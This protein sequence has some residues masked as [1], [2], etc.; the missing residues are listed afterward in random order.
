[1]A[2]SDMFQYS[3]F[4][5]N[6]FKIEY[7]GVT[8]LKDMCGKK[9]GDKIDKIVLDPSNGS[10]T[11]KSYSKKIP[12]PKKP[13][14]VEFKGVHT[15]FE[16]EDDDDDLEYIPNVV[17]SSTFKIFTGR[18]KVTRINDDMFDEFSNYIHELGC[19]SKDNLVI[20]CATDLIRVAGVNLES[21]FDLK[22]RYKLPSGNFSI[23]RIF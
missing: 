14:M 10:F 1:M 11:V 22:K 15:R 16:D 21:Y 17:E 6:T 23:M 5:M 13:N 9:A 18:N 3:S 2:Y 7:S 20:N 4:V 19:G 12:V 8:L